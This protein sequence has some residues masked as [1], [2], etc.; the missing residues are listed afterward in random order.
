MKS[1]GKSENL[2]F[3]YKDGLRPDKVIVLT[4]FACFCILFSLL[5]SVSSGPKMNRKDFKLDFK[6]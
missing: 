4:E 5:G 2:D 6:S 1:V 3:A